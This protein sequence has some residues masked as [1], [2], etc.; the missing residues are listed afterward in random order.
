MAFLEMDNV[1]L[2]YGPPSSRHEVLRG[3]SLAVERNEF[4][5]IIGFSGSGKSTIVSL[6]AGLMTPD[7]GAIIVDAKNNLWITE[8]LRPKVQLVGAP[9]DGI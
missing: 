9:T 7:S 6:L 5:S 4:V 1:S 3:A 2:G 8:W